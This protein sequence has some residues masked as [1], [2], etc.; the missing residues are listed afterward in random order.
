MNALLHSI[1]QFSVGDHIPCHESVAN[2]ADASL[3]GRRRCWREVEAEGPVVLSW[4]EFPI[5]TLL[6]VPQRSYQVHVG[7]GRDVIIYVLSLILY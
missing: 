4:R 3:E 1:L 5:W 6:T 7:L 2:V